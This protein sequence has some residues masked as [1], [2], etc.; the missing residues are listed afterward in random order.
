M[1]RDSVIW[2]EGGGGGRNKS[3]DFR[4]QIVSYYLI[5]LT[6]V[7]GGND[8]SGKPVPKHNDL[9]GEGCDSAKV[10]TRTLKNLERVASLVEE[11]VNILSFNIFI[12][13]Y[14]VSAETT[15]VESASFCCKARPG[16]KS[17]LWI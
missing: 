11:E 17:T 13:S 10:L 14:E 9:H 3:Q 5:Y 1:S 12:C 6:F 7:R 16:Q 15:P 4:K 2:R 8:R